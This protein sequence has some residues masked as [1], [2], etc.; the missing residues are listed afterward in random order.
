MIGDGVPKLVERG[1]AATGGNPAQT[2]TLVPRFLEFYEG[3]AARFTRAY[4]GAEEI[5]RALSER[6]LPL[7]VVTNKPYAASHEILEKL[8]LAGFFKAVI[9]GDS[10]PERKPHPAPLL[11][12]AEQLGAA[13]SETLMVGDNH[14]DV[15]AARAAGMGAIAV[16]WGYSHVPHGELG[17]DRLISSFSELLPLLSLETEPSS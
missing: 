5:L 17:A 11:R 2:H 6:G 10:L 7:A 1:L 9:G 12:A 13:P 4:P 8:K 14:H 16:T 15:S 3:N